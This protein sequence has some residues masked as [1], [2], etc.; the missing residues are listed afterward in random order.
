MRKF[1]FES[2]YY[3]N[4]LVVKLMPL[5]AIESYNANDNE[6]VWVYD[7]NDPKNA[8]YTPAHTLTK[9]ESDS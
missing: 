9:V 8:F 6:M 7:V 2:E 3:W 4:S 5:F 1:D